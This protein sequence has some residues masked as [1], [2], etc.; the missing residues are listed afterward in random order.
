MGNSVPE[1][2]S[3]LLKVE[4]GRAGPV[5]P[6]LSASAQQLLS[7][8]SSHPGQI[9]GQLKLTCP[10]VPSA[11]APVPSPSAKIVLAAF[12]PPS[13]ALL[14]TEIS[15]NFSASLLPPLC[16]WP[17]EC[18]L[19]TLPPDPDHP[20]HLSLGVGTGFLPIPSGGL[21]PETSTLPASSL[22]CEFH[23]PK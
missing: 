14:V 11:Q 6:V 4:S 22:W 1:R 3:H 10:W 8:P 19:P 21:R 2:L 17:W 5:Y 13:L 12:Q 20:W 9:L 18:S 16:P 15:L 23:L 7:W